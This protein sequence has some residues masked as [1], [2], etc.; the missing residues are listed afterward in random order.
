MNWKNLP[1]FKTSGYDVSIRL[2]VNM[3]RITV[4]IHIEQETYDHFPVSPASFEG[5][6][7]INFLFID[8]RNSQY[9]RFVMHWDIPFNNKKVQKNGILTF[10]KSYNK[11]IKTT[12]KSDAMALVNLKSDDLGLQYLAQ[13]KLNLLK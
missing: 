9:P 1:K 3:F 10:E 4:E 8:K 11:Q 6:N 12:L 2:L 5:T 13:V 7:I